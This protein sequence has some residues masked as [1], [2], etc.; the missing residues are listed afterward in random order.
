VNP[1]AQTHLDAYA[2]KYVA[3]APS[4]W[5]RLVVWTGYLGEDGET[6]R[7]V[8]TSAEIAVV[9]DNG[10][11]GQE[12]FRSDPTTGYDLDAMNEALVGE[13]E[14]NWTLLQLEIDRDGT[15]RTD[16]DTGPAR[17]LEDS[18]TNPYW[19]DVHD[20]LSRNRPSLEQLVDR[21]RAK[22]QL[23]DPDAVSEI[24]PMTLPPSQRPKAP[25]SRDQDRPGSQ[26]S[27]AS[28]DQAPQGWF[29]R[30]FGRRG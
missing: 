3:S 26:T 20:Y 12:Y 10:L 29:G 2:A 13:P 4:H 15:V 11:L 9:Y 21:L 17:D 8:S 1:A 16:F 22:G 25:A 24:D 6:D 7:S 27:S 14:E 23:P 5:I 30:L 28:A 18:A 19:D